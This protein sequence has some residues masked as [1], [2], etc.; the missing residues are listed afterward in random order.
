MMAE[1][2]SGL[3]R[4]YHHGPLAPSVEPGSSGWTFDCYAEKQHTRGPFRNLSVETQETIHTDHRGLMELQKL[5][6]TQTDIS[7]FFKRLD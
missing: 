1:Q 6:V 2:C 5:C 4:S 3:P 7:L